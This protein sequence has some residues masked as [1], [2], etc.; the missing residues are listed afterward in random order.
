MIIGIY[1]STDCAITR[2]LTSH[3][4]NRRLIA[5]CA[6]INEIYRSGDIL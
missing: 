6:V 1:Q 4:L 5:N 3:A 2:L